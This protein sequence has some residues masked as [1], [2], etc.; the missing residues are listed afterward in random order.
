[1]A[2]ADEPRL[3]SETLRV[4]AREG[5]RL[6]LAVERQAAC[7]DCTARAGCAAGVLAE[8]A[9]EGHLSVAYPTGLSLAPGQE[10]VVSLPVAPFVAAAGLAYLL[11]PATMTL[12][13][14]ATSAFG[15]PEPFVAAF[16]LGAFA[17]GFLPLRWAER[18]GA[19]LSGLRLESVR[20][21]RNDAP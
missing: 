12:V 5:D 9:P 2:L 20:E 15:W 11:P 21:H 16:A 8:M 19:L 17:F 6:V 3:L 13:A 18:R 4:V 1:M 14:G 7:A 10:V